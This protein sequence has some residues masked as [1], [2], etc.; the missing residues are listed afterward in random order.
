MNKIDINNIATHIY[1]TFIESSLFLLEDYV[2][3]SIDEIIYAFS[4]FSYNDIFE[5]LGDPK[6]EDF[7]KFI[8]E[9]KLIIDKDHPA[10]RLELVVKEPNYY[11]KTTELGKN[12][13]KD[14]VNKFNISLEAFEKLNIN[15]KG[16]IYENICS[17]FFNRYGIKCKTY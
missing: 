13:N 4:K 9:L 16:E 17:F 14:F 10:N 7:V 2:I 8:N 11:L 12:E 6:T 1:N 3:S 5:T 15:K